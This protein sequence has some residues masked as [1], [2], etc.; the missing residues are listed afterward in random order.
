MFEILKGQRVLVID[1]ERDLCELV[2]DELA[3]QQVEVDTAS[4]YDEARRKLSAGRYDAAIVDLMGVR[5]HDVLKEFASRVPCIVLTAN[6]VNPGD[7]KRA[8]EL[9]ACLYL[10]KEL[11][12]RLDEFLARLIRERKPLWP[13]LFRRVDFSRWFGR[14]WELEDLEFFTRHGAIG[15]A[16]DADDDRAVDDPRGARR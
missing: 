13:W 3:D 1:D 6:A 8:I 5:G 10:P 2:S 12:G 14:G 16:A 11:I 7:L 9:D 15:P 4:T